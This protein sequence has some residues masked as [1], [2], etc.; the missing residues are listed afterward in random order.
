MQQHDFSFFTILYFPKIRRKKK[1]YKTKIINKFDECKK[2]KFISLNLSFFG[3]IK[4]NPMCCLC[5]EDR[6]RAMRENIMETV[7]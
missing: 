5:I 1:Y 3:I 6:K 2:M 7:F 4:N